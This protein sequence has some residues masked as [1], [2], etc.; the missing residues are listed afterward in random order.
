M[1]TVVYTKI[2]ETRKEKRVGAEEEHKLIKCSWNVIVEEYSY[3]LS[4]P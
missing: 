1:N 3:N 2:E 4:L